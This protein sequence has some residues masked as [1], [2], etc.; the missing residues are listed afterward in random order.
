MV[1]KIEFTPL[2]E[3]KILPFFKGFKKK[4]SEVKFRD[5]SALLPVLASSLFAEIILLCQ[6]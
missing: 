3:F 6:W 2:S 5:G 4:K 1:V